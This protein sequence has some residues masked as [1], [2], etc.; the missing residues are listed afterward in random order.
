MLQSSVVHRKTWKSVCLIHAYISV[1]LS[2]LS[3]KI[4]IFS[5]CQ[6]QSQTGRSEY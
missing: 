1:L 3:T 4:T 6:G 2:G 5:G